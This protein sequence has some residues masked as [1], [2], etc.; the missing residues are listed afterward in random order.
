[1]SLSRQSLGHFNILSR[2]SGALAALLHGSLL[3]SCRGNS[4][5]IV[6]ARCTT[7]AYN[8]THRRAQGTENSLRG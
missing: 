4:A 3:M 1:V 6:T 5:G 2:Y 8:G 7:V